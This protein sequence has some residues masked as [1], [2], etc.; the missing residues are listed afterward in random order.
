MAGLRS[1]L[2]VQSPGARV[3]VNGGNCDWPDINWVHYVHHAW[4]G[5]HNNSALWFRAKE[6]IAN[7]LARKSEQRALTGG[8]W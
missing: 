7:R 5:E 2:S 8:G 3:L 1:R 6:R 4:P